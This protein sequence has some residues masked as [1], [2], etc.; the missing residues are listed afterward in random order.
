MFGKNIE[1]PTD[2]TLFTRNGL[3]SAGELVVA[4]ADASAAA[5]VAMTKR[6]AASA[7]WAAA[8][9]AWDAAWV[10]SAADAALAAQRAAASATDADARAAGDEIKSLL[11]KYI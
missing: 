2:F 4:R 5:D 10:A 1:P 11:L 8:S 7:K 3:I 6:A 9:A